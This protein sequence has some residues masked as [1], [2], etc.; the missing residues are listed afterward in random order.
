MRVIASANSDDDFSSRS[1]SSASRASRRSRTTSSIV[2]FVVSLVDEAVDAVD[3]PAC[4]FFAMGRRSSR[5]AFARGVRASAT[6]AMTTR[7]HVARRA[8]RRMPR[9]EA[10]ARENDG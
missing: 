3:V 10:R 9:V 4:A 7:R 6:H 8:R 5:E 1:A 2:R